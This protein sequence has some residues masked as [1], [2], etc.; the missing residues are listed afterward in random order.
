MLAMAPNPAED[1]DRYFLTT[2]ALITTHSSKGDNVMAAEWTFNVSYDPLLIAVVVAPRHAT[3]AAIVESG[4]FGVSMA[5]TEQ[6]ALTSFAGGFSRDEADKLSADAVKTRPGAVIQAK[7]VEGALAQLECK[8][9]SQHKVGDHTMFIGEVVAGRGDEAKEPLVLYR[10]YRRLGEKVV[11]GHNLF[12]TAT[13]EGQGVRADG[14]Y[15]ADERAGK[16]VN[17][18]AFDAAGAVVEEGLATTD[19]GGFFEWRPTASSVA[20]VEGKAAGVTAT[21]S[22]A[23]A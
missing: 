2:V 18:R 17:L 21:A 5:S 4:E 16:S 9:V 10:G 11:R 6:F 23:T 12:V 7:L 3:H 1:L 13:R 8:L 14:F 20:R 19:R 15:Y 22:L